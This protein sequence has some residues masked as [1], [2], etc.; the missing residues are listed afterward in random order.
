MGAFLRNYPALASELRPLLEAAVQVRDETRDLIVSEGARSGFAAVRARFLA[1][2][3]QD[4]VPEGVAEGSPALP[5][6]PVSQR[7]DFLVLL[8]Y[9]MNEIRGFTQAVKMLLLVGEEGM[10]KRFVPD[11]YQHVAYDYG[12]FDKAVYDDIA[13]LRRAGVLE[14]VRPPRRGR[15]QDDDVD[16][17]RGSKEVEYTFRLTAK[18][19][20]V[21]ESLARSAEARDPAILAGVRDVS[22]K[23]GSLPLKDLVRL[24]Y[25]RYPA[26]TTKSKI[27]RRVLGEDE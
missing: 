4:T 6:I 12:P 21:A 7:T 17:V 22:S 18:G 11:Y 15:Q 20:R 27:R 8:L 26:L 13:G 16:L 25:E 2:P 23:Y 5:P 14:A 3:G 10:A 19:K 9:V 24:V 1:G